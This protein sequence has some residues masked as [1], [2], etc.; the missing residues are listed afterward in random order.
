MVK[1]KI[2]PN[3]QIPPV[4]AF[5]VDVPRKALATRALVRIIARGVQFIGFVGRH[6][7]RIG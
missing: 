5:A 4:H 6:P 2:V 3:D 7:K 1:A